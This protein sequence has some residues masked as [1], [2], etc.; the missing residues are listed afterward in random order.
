MSEKYKTT[1]KDK[2]CFVTFT[3]VEWQKVLYDESYKMIIVDS[4]RHCQINRGLIVYA[5]CIMTNHV[6]LIAQSNGKESLSDVLRD[7]KKYTSKEI[8]NSL[9]GEGSDAAK[10]ALEV[11]K[12][13]GS[14]LQRIKKYKV[15]QDGNQPKVLNSNKFIR[16][17]LDYI[18]NNPVEA[19]LVANP[20]NYLFSSARNYAGLVSVLE[21]ELLVMEWKT[22]K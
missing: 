14:R 15:W 6:H 17:K 3:T 2:A 5:Y 10:Q 22:V 8:T 7:L 20:E 11:F 21:I 9:K 4:I 18:H 19:G 1:E 16:Q 13:E 12:N